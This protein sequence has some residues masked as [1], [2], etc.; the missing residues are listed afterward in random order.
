MDSTNSQLYIIFK[1]IVVAFYHLITR[2]ATIQNL[3]VKRLSN[4]IFSEAMRVPGS[5]NNYTQKKEWLHIFHPLQA[6]SQHSRL[7]FHLFR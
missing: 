6:G 1:S 4:I 3:S 5:S 7:V 2:E